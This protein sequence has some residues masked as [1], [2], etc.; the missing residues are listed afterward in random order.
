M[1]KIM[2]NYRTNGRKRL[3]RLL[4]RLLDEAERGLSGLPREGKC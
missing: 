4:K 3:G 2:L 1:P